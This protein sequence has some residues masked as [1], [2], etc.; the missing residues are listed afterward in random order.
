MA[1]KPKVLGLI[2]ARGGSKRIR[3]KNIKCL[4]GKPLIGWTIQA[5]LNSNYVDQVIVSTEDEE[6]AKT[7]KKW[8]ADVPFLRPKRLALDNSTRNEVVG[9]VLNKVKGFEYVILLQPTSPL[10]SAIHIDEAFS[11]MIN[12]SRKN[13]V[14]VKLQHP[15]PQY[16]F[17]LGKEKKL[18]PYNKINEN[19]KRLRNKFGIDKI[20]I[21]YFD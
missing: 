20:K 5:A 7:S 14:S 13:C 8:G 16:I 9:D 4:S 21:V 6:I 15:S 18:T 19:E 1:K 2:P 3:G 17:Q 12:R 11:Q 10:R